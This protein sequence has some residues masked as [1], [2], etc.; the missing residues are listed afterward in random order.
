MFLNHIS[1][2]HLKHLRVLLNETLYF[3]IILWFKEKSAG[4]KK[5]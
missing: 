2:N 1:L 5:N 3:H 4:N